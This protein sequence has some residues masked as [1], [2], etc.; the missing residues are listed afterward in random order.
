MGNF[1][2]KKT[3]NEQASKRRLV[4]ALKECEYPELAEKINA[5]EENLTD[6]ELA[7]AI[8]A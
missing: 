8:K 4:Q 1:A 6:D 5:D 7:N 2:F 3:M